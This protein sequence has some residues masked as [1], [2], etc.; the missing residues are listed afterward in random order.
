M[1]T[2]NYRSLVII[3]PIPTE[4]S[5]FG[6]SGWNDP[7][8]PYPAH[9][10]RKPRKTRKIWKFYDFEYSIFCYSS[11]YFLIVC[12]NIPS[13]F[14]TLPK[15]VVFFVIIKY[16]GKN[17]QHY[18]NKSKKSDFG[19]KTRISACNGGRKNHGK[20]KIWFFEFDLTFVFLY[21]FRYP[22]SVWHLC[23]VGFHKHVSLYPRHVFGVG[24]DTKN[25]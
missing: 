23:C 6:I 19:S 21:I 13:T 25:S 11:Y 3:G 22:L 7:H 10:G 5:I 9:R 18:A 4:L 1:G 20:S 14:T 15:T 17:H 16:F 24:S 12:P 8:P 2:T